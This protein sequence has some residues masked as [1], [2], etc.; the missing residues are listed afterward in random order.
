MSH[1]G[2]GY[3]DQELD[4]PEDRELN[5]PVPQKE[6]K[7][8][9][10]VRTLREWG[11]YQLAGGKYSGKTFQEEIELDQGYVKFIKSRAL[12]EKSLISC[13]NYIM[14]VDAMKEQ[15]YYREERDAMTKSSMRSFAADSLVDLTPMLT[16]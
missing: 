15:P 5:L 6:F 3:L 12:T 8:P 4:A 14:A 11:E 2:Q 7:K 1:I 9:Q 10:G 13:Q 16:A